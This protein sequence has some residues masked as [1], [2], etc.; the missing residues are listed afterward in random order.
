MS[1]RIPKARYSILL[2]IIGQLTACA[3]GV[4]LSE[5]DRTGLNRQAVIHV[6]HYE[7]ALPRLQN[8][9]KTG[10]PTPAAVRRQAAADP[11]ALVAQSLSQ[12]LAKKEKLK[13]L[14]IEPRHLPLPVAKNATAYREKF[15]KGLVLELWT[16]AWSFAALPADPNTYAVILS[17]H[18]QVV[19]R[20]VMPCVPRVHAQPPGP[21]ETVVIARALHI[22]VTD[23]TDTDVFHLSRSYAPFETMR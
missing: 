10:M 16:D 19:A 7:S 17:V 14:R 21:A 6:V 20:Q 4:R 18:A 13:N 23:E 9:A 11:A 2:L 22:G 15:R 12:L 3:A 5:P 1:L 8:R